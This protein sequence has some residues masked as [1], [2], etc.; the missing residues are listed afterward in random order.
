[1]LEGGQLHVRD[2]T[3]HVSYLFDDPAS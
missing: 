2:F 1:V 3:N